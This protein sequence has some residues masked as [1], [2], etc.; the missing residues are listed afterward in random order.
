MKTLL[1]AVY[2]VLPLM[3][4]A[5]D[6]LY[7]CHRER[8]QERKNEKRKYYLE[9][10]KPIP[11]SIDEDLKDEDDFDDESEQMSDAYANQ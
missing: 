9:Q 7:D 3:V 6:K 4:F 1:C 10:C 2:L 5:D 11:R 8:A